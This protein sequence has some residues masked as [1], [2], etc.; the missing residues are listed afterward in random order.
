MPQAKLPAKKPKGATAQPK[1][2]TIKPS[3]A[4]KLQFWKK[5]KQDDK[6]EEPNYPPN[7]AIKAAP[8]PAPRIQRIAEWQR[9]PSILKPYCTPM[10]IAA[11]KSIDQ[12]TTS[13]NFHPINRI[14][15]DPSLAPVLGDL[16]E[17]PSTAASYTPLLR[18]FFTAPVVEGIV[19]DVATIERRIRRHLTRGV[20]CTWFDMLREDLDSVWERAEREHFAREEEMWFVPRL[21]RRSRRVTCSDAYRHREIKEWRWKDGKWW[22]ESMFPKAKIVVDRMTDEHGF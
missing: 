21:V 18:L 16:W 13:I 9:K 3:K 15:V 22:V 5:R 20:C 12:R 19:A 10:V 2:S 17:S 6:P 4:S 1:A 14:K 7:P 11:L 8:F